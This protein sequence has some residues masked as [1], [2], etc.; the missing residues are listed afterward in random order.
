[1]TI[2]LCA[3]SALEAK[4]HP[5]RTDGAGGHTDQS[6]GEYHYHHGYSAHS[7]YDMD[8]DGDLDCPYDFD[9]KTN[10]SS[11]GNSSNNSSNSS[12][13]AS[14]MQRTKKNSPDITSKICFSLFVLFPVAL[15][16]SMP[17]LSLLKY[18]LALFGT[19]ISDKGYSILFYTVYFLICAS[20]IY[21]III[22]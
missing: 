20:L 1:M 16:L 13:G 4:A 11:S 19:E 17:V 7:H 2:V 22:W 6:T 21:L 3:L 15:L 9:D 18:I 10:H 12:N 14:T 8:G 5:G